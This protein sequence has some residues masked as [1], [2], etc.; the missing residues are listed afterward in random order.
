MQKTV[1]AV[2]II[3]PMYNAEKYVG[4]LL[5][6]ILAQTF[7]DFEVIVVDDCSTDNSCAVVERY[8]SK[9]KGKLQL[10]CS[11]KNSGAP[12][13][14]N[15]KGLNFSRGEY[16]YFL[17]AD[18]IITPTALE[19]LYPIAKKFDADVVHCESFYHFSDS[20]NNF[21]IRPS[22]LSKP[23][24]APTWLTEDLE[25][26]IQNLYAIRF[27]YPVWLKLIR[28][29]FITENGLQMI[30]AQANDANYTMALV[31][32]AERYLFVPK[33]VNFYRMISDSLSHIKE[34]VP[35]TFH[36]WLNTLTKGFSYL[37]KFLGGRADF[38]NN[39]DLK[40]AA[41]DIWVRECCA[42]LLEFYTKIPPFR[43]DEIIRRELAEVEDKT[44]LTAFLFS[45][46]NVFNVN[47]I[48]RNLKI[49]QLEN[50][51]QQL[52]SQLKSLQG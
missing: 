40:H 11:E 44:A 2:S 8:F 15:N 27:Y 22:R 14:P 12:G 3:I 49:S 6:S 41:L 46:M 23:I 52:K 19:E 37:D 38:I 30:D 43:V 35:K 47:F 24:D 10:L 16:I 25:E 7:K 31:L 39:P 26:R 5:E 42:Y 36:K 1:P 32:S 20:K 17:E 33:T 29:D 34:D 4:E 48:D 9:F 28:R 21:K 45:R 18:D 50:Q 13:I 51:I